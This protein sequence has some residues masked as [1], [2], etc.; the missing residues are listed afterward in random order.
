MWPEEIVR[1]GSGLDDLHLHRST[2]TPGVSGGPIWG[3]APTTQASSVS[4]AAHAPAYFRD[5]IAGFP[6][7]E[8]LFVT[9]QGSAF[10][11]LRR[12]LDH[13][14]LLNADAAAREMPRVGLSEALELLVLIHAHDRTRFLAFLLEHARKAEKRLDE[15]DDRVEDLP[16]Q[17]QDDIRATRAEIE[18]MVTTRIEEVRDSHIRVRLFG[19]AFLLAGV[20]ILAVANVI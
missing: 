3:S 12:A 16:R 20:P 15:L 11:R 18:E 8:H 19:I 14:S 17:W 10:T 5:L 6:A 4:G 7:W 1:R 9:S 2:S 13:E